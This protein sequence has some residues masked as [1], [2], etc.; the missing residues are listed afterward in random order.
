MRRPTCKHGVP[1]EQI[2]ERCDATAPSTEFGDT[3]EVVAWKVSKKCIQIIALGL[4]LR[5][6]VDTAAAL[7]KFSPTLQR[8]VADDFREAK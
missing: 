3:T 2:C 6:D 5:G 7:R 1:I 4:E 8:I